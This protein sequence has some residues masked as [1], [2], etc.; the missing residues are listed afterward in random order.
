M[1]KIIYLS[2][3]VLLSTISYSGFSQIITG[4]DANKIVDGASLIRYSDKNNEIPDFIKFKDDFELSEK[5]GILFLKKVLQINP[6]VHFKLF[7]TELVNSSEKTERYYQYYKDELFHHAQVVFNIRDHIIRSIS[8]CI[9]NQPQIQNSQ[10]LS[11]EQCL[12]KALDAVPAESYMWEF[13]EEERLLKE[14]LKD[15]QASYFPNGEKVLFPMNYPQINGQYLLCYAFTIYAHQPVQKFKVFINAETGQLVYKI[16]ELHTSDVPG[17]AMTKYSGLQELTTDSYSGVYRLREAARGDG[18]ETYNMQTGTSY[19]SAVDFIDT[20]NYWNNFNTAMD[21]VATDAHWGAEMTYDYYFFE[22]NRNSIDNQGFKLKSYVHYDQ[23]YSNAFWDG[24]RMT[25]GDGNMTST[26]P[27]TALDIC[28]HE[29]S[30]GLTSFTADLD[31]A[32]ESGALNEGFSDIFGTCIEF[33][34]KPSMANWLIGE[35]IGYV[36]R[37]MSNP[38]YYQQPDTYLGDYW[39]TGSD[40]NGG[41]HTNSGVLNYWFYL[42]SEGGSGTN[43]LGNTFTVSG[44]GID[45]ASQ[46][47]YRTLVNYLSPSS[48]YADARFYSIMSAIDLFGS[49]SDE[50]EAVTRAW[51]AVGVGPDYVNYVLSDFDAGITAFCQPPATVQFENNSVNGTSFLWNFGDGL[52]S[53]SLTPSHIYNN[54]GNYTVTLIVDGGACGTDTLEQ[55]A[56]ISIDNSNPCIEFMNQSGSSTLTYCNG[57]LYDSGGLNNYQD[58]TEVSVTIAPPGALNVSLSFVSFN[59]EYSYDYLRIYDGPSTNSTLIGEYTGSSIPPNIVS[60]GGSITIRQSSDVYVTESGFELNWTC[61]Y[62]MVPPVCN[63]TTNLEYTCDGL[64]QFNDLSINGPDSWSWDFGDGSTSNMQNPVHQ[65]TTEGT[66]SVSL[67]VSNA[68]G[69][70]S[71]VQN[72]YI[73]YVV[74]Q[75]PSSQNDTICENNNAELIASGDNILLWYNSLQNGDILHI[76]DTL[77]TPVLSSSTNYFV[78]DI[79]LSDFRHAGK[80]D[81]SGGGSYFNSAFVHYLVFDVF[82]DMKLVSVWVDA[83]SAGNRRISLNDANGNE[84]MYKIVYIP[85]GESRVYLN[86]D[87]PPGSGYQLQA[88]E[89]PDLYRNNAVTDYPYT[90]NGLVNVTHSSASTNPTGYYYYFYDWE[91]IETSCLSAPQQ[92]EAVVQNIPLSWF[93]FQA[94]NN[95]ISFTNSSSGANWYEW[96]FG[97]GT[98]SSDENPV[99][100]YSQLGNYS[101]QLVA[102]NDCGTDTSIAVITISLITVIEEAGLSSMS[103]YP[104]PAKNKVF[105]SFSMETPG[106]FTLSLL[107]LMGKKIHYK[108]TVAHSSTI[109]E[110]I[111]LKGLPG[112]LYFIEIAYGNTR[113]IRKLIITQ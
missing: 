6:Q 86:F 29:I 95:Q 58:D 45:T 46:V 80:P 50:V 42:L 88:P 56:F 62:G 90:I 33:Y 19:S 40:D 70:D 75:I 109:N 107:D 112:G 83:G 66:Y 30:H 1:K 47:A 26:T 9:E 104:N 12:V 100:S 113:L 27:F 77:T 99:H 11:E 106:K 28:G 54:Y 78:Q 69:S 53:T 21:E 64:V 37:S 43:D 49:C 71:L 92:V 89:S 91:V 65:Y 93:D 97:D 31:Y 48:G 79:G 3:I 68:Y 82:R 61:S 59:F 96:N 22:H 13:P 20:N 103:Y 32:Y 17:T 81:Q 101:V 34:G 41:V 39:Y 98:F 55:Q 60:S 44:L 5:D 16:N 38:N 15:D 4:K 110:E 73:V 25:Y 36:I 102:G 63:F 74:P 84:L 57:T 23:A 76:G 14:S 87:I 35:D 85:Q 24:I 7:R 10:T 111:N 67:S 105:V 94:S 108:E 8:L 72:N 51:Y 2:L 52:T 18:I